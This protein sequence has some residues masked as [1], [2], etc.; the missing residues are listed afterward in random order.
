[1]IEGLASVPSIALTLT[2]NTRPPPVGVP[3]MR[4]AEEAVA[5]LVL[6]ASLVV[7]AIALAAWLLYERRHRE[8]HLSRDDAVHF[9]R[10]D[11]RRAAVALILGILAVGIFVGSRVSPVADRRMNPYFAQI[12][13][14]VSA[15]VFALLVLAM[16]D[17]SA[18]RAYARRHFRELARERLDFLSGE[19]GRRT[20]NDRNGDASAGHAGDSAG[21]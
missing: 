18:T 17:W 3:L 11:A 20:A 4:L 7:I 5:S 2:V 16:V 1:M 21:A 12:W 6:S 10:Q 13:L 8:T 14:A 19:L 9:A 15:L